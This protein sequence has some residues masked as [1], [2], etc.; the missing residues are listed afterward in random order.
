VLIRQNAKDNN[1][2]IEFQ[3]FLSKGF[4]TISG[5]E[6]QLKH[7]FLNLFKNLFSFSEEGSNF[8]VIARN[9]GERI[10]IM[11]PDPE[12]L[13]SDELSEMDLYSLPAPSQGVENGMTLDLSVCYSIIEGL[14]G[15]IFAESTPGEGTTVVVKIPLYEEKQINTID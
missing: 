9:D 10:E 14:G 6:I 4:N 7:L 2:K 8:C 12:G 11:I 15:E 13:L 3:N 1:I 5:K